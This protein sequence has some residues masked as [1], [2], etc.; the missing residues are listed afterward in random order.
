MPLEGVYL[1]GCVGGALVLLLGSGVGALL[2][3]RRASRAA[4]ALGVGGAVMASAAGLAAALAALGLRFEKTATLPW[5][6]P[7]G[8]FALGLDPLSAFFLIPTFLLCGLAA[9]YAVGY[10]R[11]WNGRNPGRFWLFYNALVASM[12]L[13]LLARNGVLFLVAWEAMALTSFFLVI[14]DDAAAG[15][16]EAGWTYLV[17]SHV[18]MAFLLALFFLLGRAGGSQ[19]FAAFAAPAGSA[20]GLFLLALVGFGTKAGLV[21]FHVWLPEAHPAAPSPVSAVMSGVMIKTGI[22][23]ILRTLALVGSVPAWCAWLVLGL[24]VASGVYGVLFALAQRDLKRLLAYSSV[25]NVGIVAIGVGLGLLGVCYGL[26]AVAALGF[27]G[28]MLHVLNHAAFKG[29]LFLGA[30]AVVHATGTRD[31]ERLGGL[32][33]RLPWTG[34][35]FLAGA[36][37]ICGLPPFNGFAGE[38][39]IYLGSFRAL[40]ASGGAGLGGVAAVVALA[41]IG[42]L[43]IACFAR[44]FGIVFLGEPR[45]AEAERGHETCATMRGPMVA[46]AAICLALGLGAGAAVRMMEPAVAMLVGS[47]GAPAG[48]VSISWLFPVSGAAFALLVGGGAL[49]GLRR[50]LLA[51]RPVRETVTWDCGYAAPTARMQYTAAGFAQPLTH[52]AEVLLRPQVESRL[53]EGIFPLAAAFRSET[54]DAARKRLFDPLFRV[55]ANWLGRLRWLQQGRVHRYVL[56]VVATLVA[57]LGWALRR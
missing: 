10:F 35:A 57:L 27:A 8:S 30:G 22:Y 12:A 54:E 32:L 24:G 43:A 50:W 48:A 2:L 40:L 37:A 21:P 41:L 13:V 19:D 51:G 17:A 25:E 42:G 53:P 36:I 23:G 28:G 44:A 29:L 5:S 56:Y 34:A 33:K 45:T 4:N 52:G 11:P 31:V 6:F 14:H 26:P 47:A 3:G 20:G 1:F 46:L 15:V 55:T 18:G 38:F 49:A 9:I 39:L 7:Y 16:R